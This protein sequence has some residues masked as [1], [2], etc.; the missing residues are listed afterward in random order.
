M[1]TAGGP[2]LKGIGRSGDSDLVLCMDAHDAGSYPGEPTSNLLDNPIVTWIDNAAVTATSNV[3][4]GGQT[5]TRK[6]VNTATGASSPG[7]FPVGIQMTASASTV[8]TFF[9]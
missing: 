8:Y 5:F 3:S 1:S 4:Y 7:L 2:K 9:A 6:C